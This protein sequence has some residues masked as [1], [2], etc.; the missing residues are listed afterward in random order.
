MNINLK[1]ITFF[2]IE[3]II[4]LLFL[5]IFFTFFFIYH[6]SNYYGPLARIFYNSEI[7]KEEINIYKIKEIENID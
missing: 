4:I 6:S 1:N 7:K 5:E 2:L 3:N